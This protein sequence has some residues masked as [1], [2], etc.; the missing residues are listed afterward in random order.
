MA[1]VLM[2]SSHSPSID[3]R[4]TAEANS[5]AEVGHSVTI[6]SLPVNMVG[7]ELHKRV[8]LL[9]AT[10]KGPW[11][12]PDGRVVAALPRPASRKIWDTSK[13]IARQAMPPI[14]FTA[15]RWGY[16]RVR[17]NLHEKRCTEVFGISTP[18]EKFDVVHCHD[19]DTLPAA[20]SIR[21]IR[22]PRA[23]IVY[24]AHELFPFQSSDSRFQK[25]WEEVEKAHIAQADLIITVN[26]S[27]AEEMS[28]RY[29]VPE[30]EVIYN[31]YGAARDTSQED[32]RD[33]FLAR[34][35]VRDAGVIVLFQGSLTEHRNLE[36]TVKSFAVLG[37]PFHLFVLGDGPIRE[38]L[39]G[40]QTKHRIT[41]VHFSAPVPQSELL[42]YTRA[43]DIG[44]IPYLGDELLNNRLCTPNKLFEFI[45]CGVT[46]CASDLPELRRI[47]DG[48]RIGGV[49]PMQTPEAIASALRDCRRRQEAGEFTPAARGAAREALS[50]ERQADGLVAMY[51][52]LLKNGYARSRETVAA[53]AQHDNG[54][55]H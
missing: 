49:Y 9:I 29:G 32:H 53:S 20:V 6:L 51:K 2:I 48:S 16:H 7:V 19:L 4:I 38:A 52:K 13:E 43:A 10:E 5:L 3:R 25:H 41:N 44:I 31:S 45:E 46:I 1:S 22:Q 17:P 21:D 42:K 12:P 33:R 26:P 23:K 24:D 39:V 28:R 18:D 27:I 47:V 54:Q 36:N 34:F 14:I 50:W 11:V 30:P 37:E 40:I 15:L 35:G 8:R 55:R